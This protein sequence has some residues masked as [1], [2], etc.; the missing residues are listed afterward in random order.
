MLETFQAPI[1]QNLEEEETIQEW[2]KMVYCFHSIRN[3][4]VCY[5]YNLEESF[6]LS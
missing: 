1:K 3:R 5:N 6:L 4:T 2:P